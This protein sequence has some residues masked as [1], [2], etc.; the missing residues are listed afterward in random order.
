MQIEIDAAVDYIVAEMLCDDE[1]EAEAATKPRK[2]SHLTVPYY[3][4]TLERSDQE[5]HHQERSSKS[6]YVSQSTKSASNTADSN[7][8]I[9]TQPQLYKGTTYYS[10]V[11]HE[12]SSAPDP[13]NP[14]LRKVNRISKSSSLPSIVDPTIREAKPA[15][16]YTKLIGRF[17]KSPEST[18]QK[19][20]KPKKRPEARQ[21]ALSQLQK[22]VFSRSLT[23]RLNVKCNQGGWNTREPDIGQGL[24]VVTLRLLHKREA[25][26]E[27]LEKQEMVDHIHRGPNYHVF[28][29]HKRPHRND[30]FDIVT[31]KYVY[32][33][34]CLVDSFCDIL[35]SMKKQTLSRQY[36]E[37]L[38]HLKHNMLEGYQESLIWID[39]G[40]VEARH[41]HSDQIE[42]LTRPESYDSRHV[43]VYVKA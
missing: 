20:E 43:L 38:R 15:A 33:E 40:C 3:D 31:D 14:I 11:P 10:A 16:G 19:A 42:T 35:P 37:V 5:R 21:K 13:T 4:M 23:R 30:P 2:L 8:S 7:A 28:K 12:K 32:L 25:L 9:P 24:R 22:T 17:G 29:G 18:N 36:M 27:R 26:F 34:Q 1:D 6:Q 39:P 41:I